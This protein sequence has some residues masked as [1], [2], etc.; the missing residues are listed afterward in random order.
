MALQSSGAITMAQIQTEFGG[1][2]PISINEYYRG[3]S[4]VPDTGTNSGIPTSGTID[5]AD[6]YG[7]SN[8][9]QDLTATV[10]LGANS[11]SNKDGFFTHYGYAVGAASEGSLP[12]DELEF[13]SGKTVYIYN[14]VKATVSSSG[15][16]NDRFQCEFKSATGN[17]SDQADFVSHIDGRTCTASYSSTS[18]V[19]TMN[20]SNG[21]L[22]GGT[23]GGNYTCNFVSTKA[24]SAS[25]GMTTAFEAAGTGNTVTLTFSG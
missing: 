5:M 13:T 1:S 18:A 12:D 23:G 15:T 22:T 7:G 24:S 2:N 3:G 21:S 14:N 16:A 25:Q 8:V 17:F 11:G 4:N 19:I 20:T 10:T 9:S 6:F